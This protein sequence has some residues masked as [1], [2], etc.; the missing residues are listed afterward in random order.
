MKYI[1]ILVRLNSN[2]LKQVPSKRQN[3]NEKYFLR[4]RT[5]KHSLQTCLQSQKKN[6]STNNLKVRQIQM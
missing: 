2:N 4:E 1:I 5:R 6:A 3:T